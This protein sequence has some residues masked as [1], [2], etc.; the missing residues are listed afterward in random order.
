MP[1]MNAVELFIAPGTDKQMKEAAQ[2]LP[3]YDLLK[4]YREAQTTFNT[5][6]VVLVVSALQPEGFTAMTRSAYI[7]QAF[8]RW[9]PAQ[10]KI[11]PLTKETAHK[12]LKV[13][14]D[15]PA[16]WLVL[17]LPDSHAIGFC[18]IGA[19]HHELTPN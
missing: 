7:E 8:R 18:A 11:H 15:T 1:G 4:A 5:N 17:E 3:P 13:P 14:A 9:S 19:F 12:A 10:R 16:W 6:D 2:A